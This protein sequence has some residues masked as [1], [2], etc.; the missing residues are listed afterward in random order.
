LVVVGR[1][2]SLLVVVVVDVVVV[3]V[4][5]VVVLLFLCALCVRSE[6]NKQQN[7]LCFQHFKTPSCFQRANPEDLGLCVIHPWT[8]QT[9]PS[10]KCK[11]KCFMANKSMSPSLNPETETITKVKTD[12]TITT[13]PGEHLEPTGE[14]MATTTTTTTTTATAAAAAAATTTTATATGVGAEAVVVRGAVVE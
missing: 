6:K 9:R 14:Q 5:V 4:V 12:T 2:W 13:T 1:C 11:I 3:V 7:D 10:L 8:K